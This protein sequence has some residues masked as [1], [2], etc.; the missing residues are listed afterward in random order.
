V[1]SEDLRKASKLWATVARAYTTDA[2][3][4]QEMTDLA[5]DLAS[6]ADSGDDLDREFAALRAQEMQTKYGPSLQKRF[7]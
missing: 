4:H 1:S 2:V 5:R 7:G 3:A 6:A